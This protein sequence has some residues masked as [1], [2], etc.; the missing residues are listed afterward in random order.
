MPLGVQ[1]K[2]S[3]MIVQPSLIKTSILKGT[4]KCYMTTGKKYKHDK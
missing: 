1:K 3:H 2:T 4:I